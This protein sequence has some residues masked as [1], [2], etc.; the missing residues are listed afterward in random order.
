MDNTEFIKSLFQRYLDNTIS[1]EE[2]KILLK[3]FDIVEKEDLLEKVIQ[4]HLE[5]KEE[6]PLPTQSQVSLVN[7]ILGDIKNV[8]SSTKEPLKLK[9]IPF[10]KKNWFRLSAAAVIL[11]LLGGS[12]IY[13]FQQKNEAMLVQKENPGLQDTKI[14]PGTNNAYLTLDDGT[15]IMLD[16]MANGLL[17]Q[18]G[19]INVKK[20]DGEIFYDRTN[21][22][23]I[24]A[25][26]Y[27]TI[28]TANGNQYQ[29]IL[30]DG[31]KVWLNA[32]SSL[33]FPTSFVGSERK[34]EITGEAYFEISKDTKRPFIVAFNNKNGE[35][36]EIE[37]L[38][39][40]FN[41]NAYGEESSVKTTLLE[42]SIKIKK[43]GKEKMLVPGEQAVL[44]KAGITL[45]EKVDIDQVMAWKNGYFSFTHTD[46]YAFMRQV[47]RWYNVE[48]IFEGDFSK[49]NYSGMI[50]R[51]APLSAILKALEL[52][53]VEVIRVGR[54]ITVKP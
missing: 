50:S 31:S 20:I 26:V 17:A 5:L 27:N 14:S 54:I 30:T 15:V 25:I 45:N 49:E 33:R 24:K 48:V 53:D 10:Y 36:G 11:F 47:G 16:S 8:I 35:T 12:F 42:G 32:A 9:L 3:H 52:N 34:V 39:T 13:L 23:E 29:L 28:S 7:T 46:I 51:D 18:Q 38:G 2:V 37:V 19:N 44:T 21:A 6:D 1:P 41:V 4:K 40:H 43:A 22:E